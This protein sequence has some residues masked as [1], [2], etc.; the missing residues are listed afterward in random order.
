MRVH[1]AASKRIMPFSNAPKLPHPRSA[2]SQTVVAYSAEVV[3][4]ESR[5]GAMSQDRRAPRQVPDD[6]PPVGSA[7]IA[8]TLADRRPSLV[9]TSTF[10]NSNPSNRASP[11]G[12]PNQSHPSRVCEIAQIFDGTPSFTV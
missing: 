10:S 2:R 1:R 4:I 3:A 7:Y 8:D 6:Q 5:Y 9:E 12:P 11:V